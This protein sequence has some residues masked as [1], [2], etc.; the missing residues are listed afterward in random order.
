MVEMVF[1]HT[2]TYEI[3]N[4]TARKEVPLPKKYTIDR[5]DIP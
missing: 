1:L 2:C 3:P 4:K 5:I